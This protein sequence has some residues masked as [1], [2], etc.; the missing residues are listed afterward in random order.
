V[1][2]LC[3][4]PW[5]VYLQDIEED[6][7]IVGASSTPVKS[8]GC[9]LIGK[10]CLI[11]CVSIKRNHQKRAKRTEVGNLDYEVQCGIE[12]HSSVKYIRI[13]SELY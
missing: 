3:H 10:G 9:K 8:N 13:S 12:I 6:H 1:L 2:C 11:E 5:Y 7:V 4:N